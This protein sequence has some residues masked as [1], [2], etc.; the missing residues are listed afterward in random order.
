MAQSKHGC[1]FEIIERGPNN[2]WQTWLAT[3]GC[4]Q[5]WT[6]STYP[7]VEDKWRMHVHE[8]TGR[9]VTPGGDKNGRW[10]P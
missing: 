9:L 2:E 5:R 8:T 3:C 10:M 7:T 4:G 6:D 1:G